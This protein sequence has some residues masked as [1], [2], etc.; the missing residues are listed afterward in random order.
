MQN[1]NMKTAIL[2][3]FMS[4]VASVFMIRYFGGTT[5]PITQDELNQPRIYAYRDW[6]S[7]GIQI[8]PGDV[9]TFE[10]DGTWLYTP[11]EY[12]GPAGSSRYQAPSYYPIPGG[13]GGILIA[14]IGEQGKPFYVGGYR[15]FETRNSGLLYL[16]IN[17][18]ILTDNEGWV[19]VDITVERDEPQGYQ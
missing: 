12:H 17:D 8:E 3:L 2:I 14:R 6:Q 16:R 10:A 9:I 1:L 7:V 4:I 5:R 19:S 18:D 11:E 13:P 15:K